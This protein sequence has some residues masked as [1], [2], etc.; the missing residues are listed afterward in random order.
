MGFTYWPASRMVQEKETVVEQ[1][2]KEQKERRN[3]MVGPPPV[4]TADGKQVRIGGEE[5]S[6]KNER[7][8]RNGIVE[9]PFVGPDGFVT[10]SSPNCPRFK[11]KMNSALHD[12]NV[13]MNIDH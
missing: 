12:I 11:I 8:R 6:G 5:V 4:L 13:F 7:Q 3:G 1:K 10:S 9:A 2:Q